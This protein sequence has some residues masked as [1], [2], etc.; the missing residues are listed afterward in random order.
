MKINKKGTCSIIK[1]V[2]GE[3]KVI[4]RFPNKSIIDNKEITDT[5]IILENFNNY[6]V[7]IGPKLASIIPQASKCYLV[8]LT[9][10]PSSKQYIEIRGEEF[11]TAYFSLKR[12]KSSGCDETRENVIRSFYN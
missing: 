12:N 6:F 9:T 1:E 2:I 11:K 7:D 8:Y 10:V 4:S 5:S 3:K